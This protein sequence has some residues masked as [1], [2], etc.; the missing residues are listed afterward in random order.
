M[1]CQPIRSELGFKSAGDLI[2][3]IGLLIILLFIENTWS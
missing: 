1:A 3:F 2:C